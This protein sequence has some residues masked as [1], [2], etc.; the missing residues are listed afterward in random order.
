MLALI[1]IANLS[2]AH[3]YCA[4]TGLV[5]PCSLKLGLSHL[6]YVRKIERRHA[7]TQKGDVRR[8]RLRHHVSNYKKKLAHN[9]VDDTGCH[10]QP[11]RHHGQQPSSCRQ[12]PL[13][14]GHLLLLAMLASPTPTSKK[15][16]EDVGRHKQ[17]DGREGLPEQKRWRPWI[18]GGP[19]CQGHQGCSIWRGGG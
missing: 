2:N 11:S 12:P 4:F 18:C 14:S 5:P 1:G 19:Q 10:R 13:S 17:E 9:A 8:A 16:E 15:K 3:C 6:H 7:T